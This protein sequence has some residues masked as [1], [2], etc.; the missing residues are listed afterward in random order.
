MKKIIFFRPGECF[1]SP[2]GDG[3]I[4]TGEGLIKTKAAAKIIMDIAKGGIV[5]VI[6]E[7][8]ETSRKSA[9][10]FDNFFS[11]S[12]T[13]FLDLVPSENELCTSIIQKGLEM[14]IS[15]ED[16]ADIIVIIAET[17]FLIHL[18][19][20]FVRMYQ[21]GIDLDLENIAPGCGQGVCLDGSEPS[22]LVCPDGVRYE[23]AGEE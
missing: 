3:L 14:I 12:H 9:D 11:P 16:L 17:P 20:H 21:G 5:F 2:W 15:F 23:D 18:H 7:H 22:F 10:I 13:S 6:S 1:D 8:N 4:L 19:R